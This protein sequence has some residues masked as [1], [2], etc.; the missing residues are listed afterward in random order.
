MKPPQS[1]PLLIN[2]NPEH[3]NSSFYAIIEF[4]CCSSTHS[5]AARK[6]ISTRK[7]E[8]NFIHLRKVFYLISLLESHSIGNRIYIQW[9]NLLS[10]ALL[11]CGRISLKQTLENVIARGSEY[12]RFYSYRWVSSE[13]ESFR[14]TSSVTF[15]SCFVFHFIIAPDGSW[16]PSTVTRP[17]RIPFDSLPRKISHFTSSKLFPFYSKSS[18]AKRNF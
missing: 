11:S 6:P 5:S 16:T 18:P 7:S 14:G 8:I 10:L 13:T 15:E 12:I 1:F 9:S 2:P 17:G 3:W 4:F